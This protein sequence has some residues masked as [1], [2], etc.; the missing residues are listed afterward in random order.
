M[1]FEAAR[2]VGVVFCLC[3]G[4]GGLAAADQVVQFEDGRVLEVARVEPRGEMILLS[5]EG[6]GEISVPAWRV[7]SWHEIR[8]EPRADEGR[9]KDGDPWRAVAGPY[10]EHIERAAVAYRL[11][12]ALLTAVARTESAFDP[13]AVSP[14]G[15]TGLMQL[16]PQTAERFGV[17]DTFD[18]SQNV[19][20]GARYLNWLL[21][22]FDGRTD[23]AL[24]GYN[25]G[26]AAVERYEGIPPY[27]ET[28]DY[29]AKVMREAARLTE[30][31]EKPGRREGGSPVIVAPAVASLTD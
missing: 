27:P 25:A 14:K 9:T 12:P 3:V 22:R 11:N 31:V 24:A 15:A 18:V 2:S 13:L 30:A 1:R 6:G 21:K 19:D 8:P 10:A 4:S 23:L 17:A 28:E 26:E 29:V 7:A 5:I 16:M 20:G